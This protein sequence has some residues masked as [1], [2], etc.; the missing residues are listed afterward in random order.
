MRSLYS[1]LIIL[2][3]CAFIVLPACAADGD[4]VT[5]TTTEPPVTLQ[6]VTAP[7]TEPT[8]A[9]P[10][11]EP[12]TNPTT[13]PT[14]PPTTEPTVTI[15]TVV[16]TEPTITITIPP[17]QAGGG[18]GYIDV[19]SNV[20]GASVYFNGNYQG[21]TSG[22]VLSVGV[23]PTGSP[24]TTILVSKSGYNSW[25]GAPGHQPADG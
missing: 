24:V 1:S 17:T 20:D 3:L 10:T 25:T 21:V 5:T 15:P 9:P 19:Y 16:T 14:Q 13:E 23:S 8:T 11:T 12:T 7:T 6:P 18:K 22:G 2:I 4:P